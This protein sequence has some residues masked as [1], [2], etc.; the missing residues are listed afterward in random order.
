MG[1]PLYVTCHFSFVA[2]NILSFFLSLWLLCLGVFL[3]WFI[4]PGT[5]CSFWIWLTTSFPVLGKFSAIISPNI[6]S[7]PHPP[8]SG[9]PTMWMM[10]HSVLFQRSLR[11]SP[12]FIFHS[13]FYILF[14]SN[15][16]YHYV[17]QVTSLFFCINYSVSDSSSVLFTS[18]CWLFSSSVKFLAYSAFFSPK[19]YIIFTIIVL[20]SFSGRS[21]ISTSFSCFSGVLS[22]SFIWNIILCIFTLTFWLCFCSG[23]SVVVLLASC[24]PSS[25]KG[26]LKGLFKFP[27]GRD[28]W[29]EKLGVALVGRAAIS[30]TLIQC[31]L[32][33][34][35]VLPPC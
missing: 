34:G 8:L 3:L 20:N 12:F 21:S 30:K 33:G 7:G 28:W 32:M 4:L 13:F 31:L 35:A 1:V 15:D 5:L 29:W 19:S 24:L 16:F 27:D 14:C 22:C 23:D 18:L 6:F 2:L 26:Y 25:G 11:L 10:V 17:F 9:T